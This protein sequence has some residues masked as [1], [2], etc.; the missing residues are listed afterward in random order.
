MFFNVPDTALREVSL[1]EPVTIL[2]PLVAALAAVVVIY[3]RGYLGTDSRFWRSVRGVLPYVDEAARE[4]G[5]YTSYTIDLEA[6]LAGTW[7]GTLD[8]LDTT[9]REA[10][11]MFGPLAA[12][13]ETGDGRDEHG[14]YVYFGRDIS[15]WPKPIRVLYLWINVYQLHITIFPTP[16]G[17][18]WIL[19]AH[20]EYSA[21]SPLW[22]LWHLRKKFYDEAEGVR[23]T[24]LLLEDADGFIPTKR[25]RDLAAEAE[26]ASDL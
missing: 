11:A 23:R 19:T 7:P 17:E 26:T 12:H 1:S 15:S 14:S 8:E 4:E 2:A 24:V 6:E 5:F 10:G 22:A 3:G 16:E 25:A 13:K 18:G 21:Y 9:L 20:Y